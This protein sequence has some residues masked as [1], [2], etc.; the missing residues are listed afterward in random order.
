MIN[1]KYMLLIIMIAG[2]FALMLQSF[3]VSD[4]M[5]NNY[6]PLVDATKELRLEA[7]AAHLW[8][9]EILSGDSQERVDVV[10]AHIDQAEWYAQAM[11]Y[12]GENSE[13]V[14]L[15][16]E[17]SQLRKEITSVV[18]TLEEFKKVTTQRYEFSS[19]SGVGTEIDQRYDSIF[20]SLVNQADQAEFHLKKIISEEGT[21]YRIAHPGL[22][23]ITAI[24]T[25]L[26]IFEQRKHDRQYSVNMAKITEEVDARKA[27]EAALVESQKRFQGL[28]E[29]VNDWVWEVNQDGIYTYASPRVS[30]LLGYGLEEVIGKTPFDFMPKDEGERVANEF[31]RILANREPFWAL[32]NTNRHKD[33]HLVVLETSGVP[34]FD[35]EGVLLGYRGIDRDIT[36]RKQ[37]EEKLRVTNR[38]LDAFVYTVSHDL[39]T[40]LT[41]IMGCADSIYESCQD[42]MSEQELFFLNEIN[43]SGEKMLDLMEDLLTLSKVGKVERPAEPTDVRAVVNTVIS[44]LS[45]LLNQ[46]D[47]SVDVDDLPSLRVPKTFLAQIFDNLIGNAIRY[48]G[49]EGCPIKVGGERRGS[50]TRF[51]VQDHGPGI[52]EDER[53]RIFDLF[54][55]GTLGEKSPGTGVGLATVQKIVRLYEGRAWVE[56][57]EGGGSTFWVEM[58]DA[59]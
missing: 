52:P 19:T 24:L 7:T 1:K 9:E 56:E 34:F 47:V 11:L 30:A 4:K 28:V 58:A 45:L 37:V 21:K 38:E 16:L 5:I 23:V 31:S 54:Y 15:P 12:G 10:F 41:P 20:R 53:N 3:Y 55:R 48:S 36:E 14:L 22:I 29:T 2:I 51:Y 50:L 26:I 49:K 13:G 6:L 35:N 33:G 57:T 27:S 44:D 17:D 39:R 46:A 18:S 59:G 32:E 25:C 8:F 42:R 40:H 43:A